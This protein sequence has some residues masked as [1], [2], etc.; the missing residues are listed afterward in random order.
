MA[1]ADVDIQ[2][3]VIAAMLEALRVLQDAVDEAVFTLERIGRKKQAPKGGK[4]PSWM[5]GVKQAAAKGT[6]KRRKGP[7]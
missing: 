7:R 3:D 1:K 2:E 6:S 5:K 4:S